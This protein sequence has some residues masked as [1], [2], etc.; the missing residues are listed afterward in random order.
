[1]HV[2]VRGK[3]GKEVE[4]GNTLLLCESAAGYLLDWKVYREQAPS[5]YV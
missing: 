2:L 1:M 4:F 5:E 3:A